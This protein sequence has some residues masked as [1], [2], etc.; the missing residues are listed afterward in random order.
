MDDHSD[1]GEPEG[2]QGA[3]SDQ[4]LLPVYALSVLRHTEAP[5]AL[6]D[7]LRAW[8]VYCA[9]LGHGPAALL[10]IVRE[11]GALSS[12]QGRK[13]RVKGVQ[14]PLPFILH[15]AKKLT[16][17]ICSIIILQL[18][19]KYILNIKYDISTWPENQIREI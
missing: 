11:L 5:A 16:T 7:K 6:C 10:Y 17:R 9:I 1:D 8:C 19:P 15:P 12:H 13:K 3:V 4:Y 18:L 2:D 14:L